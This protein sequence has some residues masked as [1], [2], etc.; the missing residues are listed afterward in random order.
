MTTREA[1][2]KRGWMEAFNCVAA[3]YS[4]LKA[5]SS[6][7]RTKQVVYRSDEVPAEPLDF[8][9][10]VEIKTKR[11][12]GEAIY[13]VFLRAVYNEQLDILPEYTREALGRH[14][15]SY[16]LGPEGA[17]RRLYYQVKNEQIR[18]FLKGVEHVRVHDPYFHAG[19]DTIGV[20]SNQFD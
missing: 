8:V 16:G 2:L 1:E 20:E 9:L 11:L 13:Q 10:D 17:Y 19:D 15:V 4:V 5:N 3:L 6:T 7:L 12:L 14:W 18:S